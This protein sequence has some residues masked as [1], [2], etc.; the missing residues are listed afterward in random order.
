MSRRLLQFF[1]YDHLK[2]DLQMV[3]RSFC[4]LAVLVD[5]TLPD[6]P[7]RDEARPMTEEE[8]IRERAT[9]IDVTPNDEKKEQPLNR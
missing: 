8:W 5:H 2:S 9:L 3:S 4:D 1:T 7:E 6:N